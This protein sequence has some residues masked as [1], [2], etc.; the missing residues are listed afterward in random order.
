[1]KAPRGCTTRAR[2]SGGGMARKQGESARKYDRKLWHFRP[3]RPCPPR[4]LLAHA[5]PP[6]NNKKHPTALIQHGASREI[7][8]FSREVLHSDRRSGLQRRLSNH[9]C[10]SPW[11]HARAVLVKMCHEERSEA[12]SRALPAHL[13]GR[14][15]GGR[16]VPLLYRWGRPARAGQRGERGVPHRD[17]RTREGQK[18]PRVSHKASRGQK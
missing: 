13:A 5:R 7:F 10:T 12:E 2:P 9:G 1:M 16:L 8:V 3:Q 14:G 17:P 11:V 15:H 4:T 6:N 18:H